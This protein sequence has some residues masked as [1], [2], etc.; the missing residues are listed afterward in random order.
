MKCWLFVIV[1]LI[2]PGC[3]D[4]GIEPAPNVP[5]PDSLATVIKALFS[6]CVFTGYHIDED[7][8]YDP[9]TNSL[10]SKFDTV[11][12]LSI[13]LDSIV[14]S[15][16]PS[17]YRIYLNGASIYPLLAHDS[18]LIQRG[19]VSNYHRMGGFEYDD[20]FDLQKKFA[21][22][23]FRRTH[24]GYPDSFTRTRYFQCQE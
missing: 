6:K 19:I 23:K 16:I 10:V 5:E 15:S 2:A 4:T 9:N 22:L 7:V 17:Y 3:H 18:V 11:Y 24:F 1:A 12:N 13:V 21:T 8:K 14:P 20:K